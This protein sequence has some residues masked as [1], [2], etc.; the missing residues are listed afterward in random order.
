MKLW[1]SIPQLHLIDQGV[2]VLV[3]ALVVGDSAV[4]TVAVG[5]VTPGSG[6]LAETGQ[7]CRSTESSVQ[8]FPSVQMLRVMEVFSSARQ[9][10][11]S[12]ELSCF[13]KLV[14]LFMVQERN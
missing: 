10:T 1:T 14:F 3:G 6:V 11:I 7:A 4:S 9:S 12:S 2:G 8:L 13:Q 5:V